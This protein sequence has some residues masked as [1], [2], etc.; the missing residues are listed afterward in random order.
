LL[1]EHSDY[2][3]TYYAAGTLLA[4][5]NNESRA[6]EILLEGARLAKQ[7]ADEKTYQ[8]LQAMIEQLDA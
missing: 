7:N 6:R 8:E 2:L 1:M 4:E 3:P 5:V